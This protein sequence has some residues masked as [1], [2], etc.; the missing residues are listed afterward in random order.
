MNCGARLPVAT[1]S[2]APGPIESSKS[3][4]RGV[5]GAAPP[6]PS[7]QPRKT[8]RHSPPASKASTS[9]NLLLRK[10]LSTAAWAFLL[11]CLFQITRKPDNVLPATAPDSAVATETFSTLR[12]FASS[13][14][15]QTWIINESRINQ[16]LASTLQGRQASDETFHLSSEF[17]RAFVLF[18]QGNFG[19]CI[20]EKFLEHSFYFQLRV[21][22][23][24]SENALNAE[25]IGGNLGRLPI[26]PSLIKVVLPIFQPTLTAL[27]EILELLH[28]AKSATITPQDATLNWAA[29]GTQTP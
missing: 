29:S 10:I 25:F 17:Q 23:L 18:N 12:E 13:K 6:L 19:F 11:A 4:G 21:Q 3:P 1:P 5:G 24:T 16:F 2:D 20:E 9:G 7:I 27:A 28:T 26:H 15:P 14:K 8:F 22:P